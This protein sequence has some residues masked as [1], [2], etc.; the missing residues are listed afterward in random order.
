MIQHSADLP[1]LQASYEN[2]IDRFSQ[3][4]LPHALLLEG[5]SGI[6][7]LEFANLLA[8]RLVCSDAEGHADPCGHCKQCELV[9]AGFHP[10]IRACRPEDSRFIKVDQVRSLG[11]FAVASPQVARRKVIIVDSADQLNIN[12][13]NALLKTL[14][15]PNADVT[16]ILL[17]E[18]GK[19]LLPTLRSRCQSLNLPTPD[20]EVATHWLQQALASQGDGSKSAEGEPAIDASILTKALQLTGGAPMLAQ[21]YIKNDFVTATGACLDA[22]R[23]FLKSKVALEVASKTFLAIGLESSLGVMERWANDMARLSAGA[24][25]NNENAADVLGFLAKNNHPLAAHGLVEKI[26]EARSGLTYNVNPELEI[27]RLLLAWLDLMPKRRR[28]KAA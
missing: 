5:R 26:R 20:I 25:A 10:D 23:Q 2:L 27:E 11:E 18:A 14:E 7:E 22:F 28:G 24:E 12:A 16:L 21:S 17:L 3:G 15:E 6:G 9:S 4:R 13:A 1:W 19:P 8:Q